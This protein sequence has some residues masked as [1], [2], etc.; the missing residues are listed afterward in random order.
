MAESLRPSS[1]YAKA[2]REYDRV[3]K[4]RL[5]LYPNKY[6]RAVKAALRAHDK[7]LRDYDRSQKESKSYST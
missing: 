5:E 4:E 2:N 6:S 3:L 1:V 7:V